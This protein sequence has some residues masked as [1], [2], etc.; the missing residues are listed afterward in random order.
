M[1]HGIMPCGARGAST[2]MRAV[3]RHGGEKKINQ[4][5]RGKRENGNGG[6]H[7]GIIQ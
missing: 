6:R 2:A 3:T 4:W 1:W 5:R 7:H